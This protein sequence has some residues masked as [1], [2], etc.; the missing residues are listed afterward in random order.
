MSIWLELSLGSHLGHFG[1]V[2]VEQLLQVFHFCN[3][4]QSHTVLLSFNKTDDK[5]QHYG[6]R[7]YVTTNP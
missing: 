7:G 3:Q 1:P 4:T 6:N 5:I 2:F